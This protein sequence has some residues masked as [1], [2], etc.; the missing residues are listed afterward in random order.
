MWHANTRS[1]EMEN[2]DG[3]FSSVPGSRKKETDEL[4]RYV[5]LRYM[6]N[7][8]E[9]KAV[10]NGTSGGAIERWDSSFLME[11]STTS[12]SAEPNEGRVYLIVSTGLYI[13]FNVSPTTGW[14]LFSLSVPFR[15]C[16]LP[17]TFSAKTQTHT[18]TQRVVS[19]SHTR[20][21]DH[22]HTHGSFT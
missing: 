15:S 22:F 3:E 4:K 21:F 8:R 7:Q 16:F 11:N 12:I 19:S 2:E 6:K 17:I 5:R 1:V 14:S 13:T 9:Y 18:H 20:G 10:G